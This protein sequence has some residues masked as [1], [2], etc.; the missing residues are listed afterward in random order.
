MVVNFPENH[1]LFSDGET[2]E[3]IIYFWKEPYPLQMARDLSFPKFRLMDTKPGLFASEP[4]KNHPDKYPHNPVIIRS[5]I[6]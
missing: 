1:Q 2:K 3:D 6:R 5:K 4:D